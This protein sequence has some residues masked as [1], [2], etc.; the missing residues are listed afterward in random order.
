MHTVF[1]ELK[2]FLYKG[3]AR[4]WFWWNSYTSKAP[5]PKRLIALGRTLGRVFVRACCSASTKKRVERKTN[6]VD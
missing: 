3:T 4:S 6:K 1:I 2:T 5:L